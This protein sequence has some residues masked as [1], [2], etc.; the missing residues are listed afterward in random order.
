MTINWDFFKLAG[1]L[2]GI[3]LVFVTLFLCPAWLF[4]TISS[5]LT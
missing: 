2:L 3:P 4:F 5:C 1:V